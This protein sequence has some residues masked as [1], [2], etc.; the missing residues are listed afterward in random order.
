M[1]RSPNRAPT[2]DSGSANDS[3]V[4]TSANSRSLV[5]VGRAPHHRD[6]QRSRLVAAATG[7]PR[8]EG[9]LSRAHG[10]APAP[11]MDAAGRPVLGRPGRGAGSVG[12]GHAEPDGSQAAWSSVI[13]H[14]LV[15]PALSGMRTG[16]WS[17]AW[18]I[19]YDPSGIRTTRQRGPDGPAR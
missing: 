11:E 1:G 9:P 17:A 15:S 3:T 18:S 2:R 14:D 5:A 12:A 8:A 7:F 10:S 19:R 13:I 16:P 6:S 4:K